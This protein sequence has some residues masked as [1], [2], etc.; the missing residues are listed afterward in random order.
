[1]RIRNRFISTLSMAI[2]A[3]ILMT[4]CSGK[5]THSNEVTPTTARLHAAGNCNDRCWYYFKI[6]D[7]DTGRLLTTPQRGP[8]TTIGTTPFSETESRLQPGHRYSF[9]ACGLGDGLQNPVCV[10]PDGRTDSESRFETPTH[11]LRPLFYAVV[12]LK[13]SALGRNIHDTALF[14]GAQIQA[15]TRTPFADYS[16]PYV[17]V[18]PN[19]VDERIKAGVLA[20]EL[21]HALIDQRGILTRLNKLPDGIGSLANEVVAELLASEAARE[22]HFYRGPSTVTRDNGSLRS[23]REA[24]DNILAND[25]YVSYYGINRSNIS[26]ADRALS[27]AI[28][29]REAASLITSLGGTVPAA[30]R[31]S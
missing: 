3:A 22:G 21:G 15:T 6:R 27:A 19:K 17:R 5:T 7:I 10:G 26:E 31:P 29:Y 30:Y 28:I 18:H 24:L 23:A 1:M 2:G 14:G 4:G 20:H 8:I 11:D 25:F 12:T 16:P 13:G 9:Q